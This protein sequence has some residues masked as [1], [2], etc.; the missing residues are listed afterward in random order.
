MTARRR[1]LL[2]LLGLLLVG[3]VAIGAVAGVS[4][5]A[6]AAEAEW[7]E[8]DANDTLD[9]D[10]EEG[11]TDEEIARVVDRSMV[12]V[13]EIRDIEFEERPEVRVITR[14]EAMT[15]RGSARPSE[16]TAWFTNTVKEGLFVVGQETDA[17]AE[18][19]AN[20][21]VTVGGYYLIGQNEIVI[22]TA[23]DEVVIDEITL[24]HELVHAWQD[25]Q[26][27]LRSFDGE[28][29]DEESALLGLIEGDAVYTETKYEARCEAEWECLIPPETN[30]DAPEDINWGLYFTDFH[31]YSDGPAFIESI[32]EAGGW[33]A[34]DAL[35]RDPPTTTR[36][37]IDPDTYGSFSPQSVDL[38]DTS[39]EAWERIEPSGDRS[40]ERLGPARKSAMFLQTP[41]VAQQ[42]DDLS[43]P[44]LYTWQVINRDAN[45]EVPRIDPIAYDRSFTD[46]WT[47]DR[48]HVYQRGDD[49]AYV[50]RSTWES[51]QNATAF[52][53]AYEDL[54]TFYSGTTVAGTDGVYRIEDGGFA[55]AY[56][57]HVDGQTLT[58]VS[59]PTVADLRTV[60]PQTAGAVGIDGVDKSD[61]VT[62]GDAPLERGGDTSDDTTPGETDEDDALP[63]PGVL[64][65]FAIVIAVG[66][67]YRL[68]RDE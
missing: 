10:P 12:R 33:D 56:A 46:G 65:A 6:G 39:T 44:P 38:P 7:R 30:G 23:G 57:V 53:E 1:G 15:D 21:N 58:I 68:R 20:R 36:H 3:M 62:A 4:G 5:D 60:A 47:G 13:E 54:L 48:F 64:L 52:A 9:I 41:Y 26:H 28:T 11:L 67:W 25:Q 42:E 32:H 18:R 8:Y 2:V 66:A 61:W 43:D 16:D 55:G 17:I 22:I 49:S 31:P 19:E 51:P 50:W 27:D 34:V 59:A 45:G 35:Y 14:E 29:R 63:A 40:A 37:V 24:A